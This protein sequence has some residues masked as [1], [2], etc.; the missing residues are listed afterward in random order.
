MKRYSQIY[1]PDFIDE[2]FRTLALLI[3]STSQR[4]KRW[5]QRKGKQLHLD[6]NAGIYGPL[7]A[8]SR[9]S[10]KF[11]YWQ[12]RLVILKQTFDDSEP[13]DVTSWWYDDRKK[14]QWYT[15]WVA[16]LV[17]ILTIFFGL[18]QTIAGLV[19]AWAAVKSMPKPQ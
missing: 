6:P 9:H 8:A 2:T 3:P 5:F 7:N 4:S 12:E 18:L 1:P 10:S 15:F 17:L 19:Q 13:H 16:F 14:V 11:H